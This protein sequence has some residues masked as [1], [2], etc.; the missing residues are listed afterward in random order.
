MNIKIL[1]RIIFRSVY[2]FKTGHGAYLTY[3]VSFAQ[4]VVIIYTLYVIQSPLIHIFPTLLVFALVFLLTYPSLA[5][6]IG[7][8]HYK[9]SPI[10]ESETEI[11]TEQN[12]FT[13]KI[14]PGSKDMFL[15][16]Y[17]IL[18]A[19]LSHRFYKQFNL[20]QKGEEEKWLEYIK[21]LKYLKD[22]GDIRL[23][24]KD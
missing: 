20:F 23:Y 2:Y 21:V 11:I 19:E 5:V 18:S 1:R 6:L 13:Y 4:W 9:R 10:Y 24:G 17:T 12:P 14:I 8:I 7:Y 22:G 15:S 3:L 16:E